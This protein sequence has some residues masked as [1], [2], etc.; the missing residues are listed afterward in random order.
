[1][2]LSKQE[3]QYEEAQNRYAAKR[4]IDEYLSSIKAKYS[5]MGRYMIAGGRKN[6]SL[7]L[8]GVVSECRNQ[9]LRQ[10]RCGEDGQHY[11]KFRMFSGRH[12]NLYSRS[13]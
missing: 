12:R 3:A 5:A 6:L 4:E 11:C 1:M 9:L 13:A 2:G 10:E 8:W 7:G